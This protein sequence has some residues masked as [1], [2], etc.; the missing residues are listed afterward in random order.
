MSR[1]IDALFVLDRN[2]Q[3]KEKMKTSKSMLIRDTVY[4]TIF[5]TFITFKN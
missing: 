2:H 5:I 3:Y 4:G 1:K